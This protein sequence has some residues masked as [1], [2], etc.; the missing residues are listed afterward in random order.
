MPPR[1]LPLTRRRF[2]RW[3]ALAVTASLAGVTTSGVLQTARL[4][5]EPIEAR[6]SGLTEPLRLAFLTDLHYGPYVDARRVSGWVDAALDAHPDAIV[7]GGDVIDFQAPRDLAPLMTQLE[8]LRAPQGTFMVLG[9]HEHRHAGGARDFVALA[10][11][12][13]VTTLHNAGV[14]LP[15]GLYLAGIDDLRDG[16]PD[17]GASL[18]SRPAG[19]PV[20][21]ASHNPD[22]LPR[23]PAGVDLVLSGHTHGGQVVL[24]LVGAPVTSSRYGQRFLSGWVDAPVPAYVSRGLGV[25]VL[26]VRWNCPPELTLVTLLPG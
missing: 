1:P 11:T 10:G 17:V 14:S 19:A 22:V 7:L 16:R 18:R 26:P 2:L 21:L 9:N 13:G 25:G 24:P 8:R 3:S 4:T 15:G 6:L 23:L 12:A 5:I 20:L